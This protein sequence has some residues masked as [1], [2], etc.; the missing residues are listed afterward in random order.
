MVVFACQVLV[1][2][3][4]WMRPSFTRSDAEKHLGNRGTG[5]FVSYNIRG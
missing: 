1:L 5:H 3:R 2:D 4:K